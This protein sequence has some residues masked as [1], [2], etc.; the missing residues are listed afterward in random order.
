[1]NTLDRE[2]ISRQAEEIKELGAENK[3]L[4][5][6][7]DKTTDLVVDYQERLVK[8]EESRDEL[9]NALSYYANMKNYKDWFIR[10]DNKGDLARHALKAFYLLEETSTE[11]EK[12]K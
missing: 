12:E 7:L 5:E 10:N 2:Y 11:V 3:A 4:K 9:S 6:T 1:M 8:I